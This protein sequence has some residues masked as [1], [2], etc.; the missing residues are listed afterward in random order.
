MDDGVKRLRMFAGPNGSGKT[1]IIRRYAREFSPDGLFSLHYYINA[2]DLFHSLRSDGIKLRTDFGLD[3][4]WEQLRSA[5]LGAKRLSADHRF[6][7]VGVIADGRL[8]CPADVCD[9]YVAASIADFLRE[10]L[11]ACGESLSFETVMSHPNKVEFFARARSQGFQT[12]LYFVA[13]ESPEINVGRVK[14]RAATGGHDVPDDK[15]RERYARCL[16]LVRDVLPYA[17]RAYFFDN[18]GA[19][20]VWLAEFGPHGDCRL[21]T[22]EADLPNWFLQWVWS[23][24]PPSSP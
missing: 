9:A 22:R 20:P 24:E 6:L 17:H 4:T 19:A 23:P 13:T 8:S 15:V 7:G 10:E 18:S 21:E 1:S 5:L 11:L 16:R 2:D 12:Y 14:T 3:V